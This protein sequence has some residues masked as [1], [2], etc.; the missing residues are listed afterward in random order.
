MKMQIIAPLAMAGMAAAIGLAPVATPASV[1]QTPGNAQV[2]TTPGAAAVQGGQLLVPNSPKG[3]T[4]T[5]ANPDV[6]E[7]LGV[8]CTS[9]LC[10]GVAEDPAAAG[11]QPV[12]RSTFSASP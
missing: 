12:P 6:P 7:L 2:T 4:T 8:P 3:F 1:V 5:A 9:H 11:P 10:I